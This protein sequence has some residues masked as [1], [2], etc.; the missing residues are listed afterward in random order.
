MAL[1]ACRVCGH[2]SL[3]VF[4]VIHQLEY[5]RCDQCVATLLADKHLPSLATERERYLQHRN[6]PFDPAYRAFLAAVANP[7]MAHLPNAQCGLDYGCGPG[8]ALACMMREA[9]HEVRLYDPIFHPDAQA[10]QG[11][12]DFVTCTEVAEHF[13][14]PLNEFKRLDELLRPGGVLAIMTNFQRDDAAFSEWHYRRDPTHVTF[15]RECTFAKIA[16]ARGWSMV[17]HPSNVVF[18][19]KEN[20]SASTTMGGS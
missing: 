4:A 10:L 1:P 16:A 5:W 3:S 19:H 15:Y 9:G 2:E 17:M 7:L 18:M 6:D 8:P 12:Y 13:H 11:T 20:G 14:R